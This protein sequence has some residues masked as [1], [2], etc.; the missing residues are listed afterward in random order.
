[1]RL[2]RE[3][4]F[5]QIYKRDIY[6][7]YSLYKQHLLQPGL[8]IIK[9]YLSKI[10]KKYQ[11]SCVAQPGWSIF[12]LPFFLHEKKNLRKKIIQIKKL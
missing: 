6:N 1:M 8:N 10:E 11:F 5:S 2:P 7:I 9:I 12:F 4:K 3:Y